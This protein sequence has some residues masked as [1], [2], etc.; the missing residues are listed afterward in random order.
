MF[1]I[2]SL[3]RSWLNVW[4]SNSSGKVGTFSSPSAITI[5]CSTAVATIMFKKVQPTVKSVHRNPEIRNMDKHGTRVCLDSPAKRSDL[6]RPAGLY[7]CHHQGGNQYWMFSK[8]GEIRR[9]EACLDYS[10]Q[11]VILYPCHGG[12]GNQYWQYD[13]NSKLLKHMSGEKCLAVNQQH[14]KLVM[15][16]C[17]RN[18][19]R[20]KW[21]LENYD[22]RKLS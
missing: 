4:G 22:A 3:S 2:S 7:P 6:H 10:G 13:P 14:S 16:Y 17:D 8:N 5:L 1:V 15:E 20:Q 12:K 18:N 11:D 21:L 9:D 19:D